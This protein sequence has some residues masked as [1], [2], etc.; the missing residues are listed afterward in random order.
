MYKLIIIAFMIC[1]F[2]LSPVYFYAKTEDK[3]ISADETIS[4]WKFENIYNEKIEIPK[5]FYP[6]RNYSYIGAGVGLGLLT[7][8]IIQGVRSS[9]LSKD[10]DK[11][12]DDYKAMTS[13]TQ[14]E[15][16]AALD[17]ANDKQDEADSAKTQMLIFSG[18]GLGVIGASVYFYLWEENVK[19]L[20]V[21]IALS[22][23]YSNIS[24]SLR[25]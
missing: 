1:S 16:K 17:K 22:P 25:F 14:S 5:K 9:S 19:P 10:A 20:P 23:E 11:L 15:F 7:F 4:K 12:F 2:L 13:G 6:Y 21:N 3:K 24:Y 8:G 18:V